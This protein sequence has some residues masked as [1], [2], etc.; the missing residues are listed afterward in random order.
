MELE[1][2]WLARGDGRKGFAARRMQQFP[3]L[4]LLDHPVETAARTHLRTEQ[5]GRGDN[6][7]ETDESTRRV[8]NRCWQLPRVDEA[9]QMYSHWGSHWHYHKS[10]RYVP[11]LF[12]VG[13]FESMVEMRFR[14]LEVVK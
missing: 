7:Q 10:I 14:K 6:R 8:R 11:K 5:R 1:S 2:E 12:L 9:R 4:I 3:Y 13:C